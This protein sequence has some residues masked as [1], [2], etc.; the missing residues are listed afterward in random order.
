MKHMIHDIYH[1]KIILIIHF[2]KALYST[3]FNNKY[4]DRGTHWSVMRKLDNGIEKPELFPKGKINK[5]GKILNNVRRNPTFGFRKRPMTSKKY[6][7]KYP[8]SNQRILRLYFVP[9]HH[10][11]FL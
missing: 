1:L 11:Y 7:R 5:Y 4:N 3:S 10:K 8:S 6:Y 2:Q 9:R